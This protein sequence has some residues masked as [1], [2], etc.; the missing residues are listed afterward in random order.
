MLSKLP[1]LS[2]TFPLSSTL[3]LR[4][5]NLL[6]GSQYSQYAKHAI[7]SI[8]QLPQ[9]SFGSDVGRDQLLHHLRFSIDYLRRAQLLSLDGRPINLFG[10]AS[11][12]YHTEPSNFALVVLLQ[13][14]IFHSVCSHPSKMT[15][16]R[17]IMLLMAQ[18]FGRRY[19]PEAYATPN[20][21][22]ELTQKY[23]S[24]IVLQPMPEKAQAVLRRHQQDILN[25][26][27]AY[28]VTFAEQHGNG[29]GSDD[30]LPLSCVEF[31]AMTEAAVSSFQDFLNSSSHEIIARSAFVANSGHG[32]R[33]TTIS[34][35]ANTVRRGLHLN[36]HAI[37]SFER[38]LG[39]GQNKQVLNAYI[40]DFF[41]HGQTKALTYA[42]GIR[43]GDIW[44]ALQD[45]ELT[46]KAIRGDLENLLLRTVTPTA[47]ADAAESDVDSGYFTR[48]ETEVD[49]GEE[50]DTS[51]PQGKRI[52][53]SG[54]SDRDW[55][56]L[57]VFDDVVNAF[58]EKFRAMWA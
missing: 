4:L 21:L 43:P 28:A 52:R 37:P 47:S 24:A 15:A 50:Q 7:H 46:L 14:G 2:G 3:S 54:V 49:A 5:F 48:D 31:K 32:D 56:V 41:I 17:E 55:D 40:L 23:P 30:A 35:L 22:H 6:H 33:F 1:R 25:V 42:N 57:E 16:Q 18:L 26:F 53:P 36:E 34:E 12:L 19:L 45:F 9:I 44:F 38:I 29:L 20:A 58:S 11:H 8:L 27:T 13:S 39:V 10:M 51:L